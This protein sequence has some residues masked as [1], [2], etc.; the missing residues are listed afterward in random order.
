MMNM[1][2][3]RT[4]TKQY[5]PKNVSNLKQQPL[6]IDLTNLN[7]KLFSFPHTVSSFTFVKC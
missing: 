3:V 4:I 2:Q 5:L 7:S 6:P 1:S